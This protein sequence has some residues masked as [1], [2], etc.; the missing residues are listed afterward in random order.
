MATKSRKSA[1]T[2]DREVSQRRTQAAQIADLKAANRELAAQL[3]EVTADRDHW[4]GAALRKEKL[5]SIYQRKAKAGAKAGNNVGS[6]F[7]RLKAVAAQ[8]DVPVSK[9]TYRGGVIYLA[10]NEVG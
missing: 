6:T 1:E 8:L 5:L 9:L 4:K 3:I 10:G 7:E 2:Q